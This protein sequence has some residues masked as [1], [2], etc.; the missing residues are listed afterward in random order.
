MFVSFIFCHEETTNQLTPLS[1]FLSHS[2]I[3]SQQEK[4]SRTAKALDMSLRY[5][6]ITPLTSML[7]KK[8]ETEDGPS[9][10]LIADKLTEGKGNAAKS[11]LSVKLISTISFHS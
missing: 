2:D 7:V 11:L 6:F 4:D 9:G 10:P 8:P 3:G 1:F 5:S